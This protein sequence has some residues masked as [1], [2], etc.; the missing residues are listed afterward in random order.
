MALKR[1]QTMTMAGD[2]LED[3]RIQ[4]VLVDEYIRIMGIIDKFH[5][6]VEHGLY[7]CIGYSEGQQC[8]VAQLREA[9]KPEEY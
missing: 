1:I 4:K 5:T 8:C 9:I 7:E 2:L 3:P 6:D